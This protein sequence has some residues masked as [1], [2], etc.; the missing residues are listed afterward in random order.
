MPDVGSA[1]T[2]ETATSEVYQPFR[3]IVPETDGTS[4]DAEASRLIVTVLLAVPP[5]EVAVQVKEKLAPS[6]VTFDSSQPAVA[7]TGVSL[8]T[9][10]QVTLTLLTY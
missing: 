10:V 3:P 5:T 1:E 9:T 6:V 8:S 2:N 7:L 4:V